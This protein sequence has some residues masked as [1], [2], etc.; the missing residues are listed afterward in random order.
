ML[1]A[2][3]V[4]ADGAL[5]AAFAESPHP[6][7]TIRAIDVRPACA[8]PGVRAVLVADDIGHARFG[9]QLCDWPILASGTVRFIGDRVAAVAA[10]TREAAEEAARAVLVTYDE[11]PAVFTAG[12]ALAAGAPVLHPLR[13]AY[14]FIGTHHLEPAPRTHANVYGALTLRHDDEGLEAA[15]AS[16]HR[17]FEHAFQTPRQLAGFIEPRATLV[18]IDAG[19]V[20][21]SSPNKGPYAFR[22][23]FAHAAGLRE[24]QVVIE[25]VAIGGDFGGK[26]LT[27]DELPCYYLARATNRPVRYVATYAE[28]L[29]R[30]PTRHETTLTL[31]SAV[32]AHGKLLAHY[33][34]VVYNGGAYAATKPIPTLLP[35]NAYGS[36]PYHVPHVRLDISGV[37]T[38]TL[39]GAHVRGPG[40]LQTF[41]AW[42][43]HIDRIA[44]A[45]DIDPLAFRMRNVARDGDAILTGERLTAPMAYDILQTLERDLPAPRPG[46]GRGISLACAHTGSGKTAVRMRLDATGRITILI[47]AVDQGVGLSTVLARVVSAELG[48][49]AER[50]T[51]VRGNTA[52]AL[53]DQGSGHSRVTHIVGRAALDAAEQ[54]RAAIEPYRRGEEAFGELAA[55]ACAAGP[56]E[57]VGRFESDHGEQ[58]PG[59]LTF[60]AY[61]LDVSV[62]RETGAIAVRDTVFVMDVGQVINPV[63][64]QGQIDGGF[65][66]GLG[67]ALM[68]D[69]ALN[70]DGKIT[71]PSLGE[72]KLPTMR[73]LP[74]LRTILVQA[75]LGDGPFGTRMVGE[76]ANVGVAAAVVNAIDAAA[77]VRLSHFAVRA[78]D[79]YGALNEPLQ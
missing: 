37:Y 39:P 68:E 59:D 2:A 35:G 11:L 10:E 78:E 14:D 19:I 61:A 21:V 6:H 45:L 41:F 27:V 24:E 7:A 71:T 58:V 3:D 9:R 33:S 53:Y 60:G 20:H 46:T 23:H 48:I 63:A 34:N 42:E 18:W 17:V 8:I 30:G 47:G 12:D 65:V 73:D 25:P 44:R 70:G 76:L 72:Y 38:N 4:R 51:T 32:D 26:G 66:M 56:I 40:E 79:V 16:A 31:R 54:L 50:I 36:I 22:R 77:G 74:P 1:Y 5:W 69:V 29:R 67:A 57:V 43:V 28:E 49:D 15:F 75:P 55:R 64:H 13:D 52:D 62:D